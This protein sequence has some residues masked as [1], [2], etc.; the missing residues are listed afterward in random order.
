MHLQNECREFDPVEAAHAVA[1]FLP[2]D[3]AFWVEYASQAGL[4]FG[5]TPDGTLGTARLSESD[6]A[7]RSQAVFL[8]TWLG[9]TPGGVEAVRELLKKRQSATA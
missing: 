1:Q 2:A 5:L 3:P 4:H 7:D 9:L 8:W 6:L